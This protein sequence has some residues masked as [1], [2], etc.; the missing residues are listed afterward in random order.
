MNNAK[1]SLIGLAVGDAV[2][3]AVEFKERGSFK[4][5]NDMIGGGPHGLQAG[6]WTD[7][8]SMALCLAESLIED[9]FDLKSQLQKYLHWYQDGYLS[10]TGRCFDIGNNTARSLEYYN[11]TGKLPPERERAAGN[12]SLMRLA[13]IPIYF[14]DNYENAVYYSGESSKTTHN[15]I[16]AIDSCRYFGGLLQLALQRE[17]SSKE[18]LLDLAIKNINLQKRVNNIARGSFKNKDRNEIYADGFVINSLEAS[19]WA[20][21]NTDSFDEAVLKVVNLG[22]DADTT[23]AIT[24]QIAGTYYGID[25]IREEWIEKLALKDQ[26]LNL[27]ERLV[28]SQ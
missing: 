22:E 11:D 26:I 6:Q 15:N 10:S 9:G 17:I 8:T 27:C 25:N 5:V 1:G 21:Y 3:A 16:L 28:K 23:G 4:E 19:L 7:D 18:E 24:G 12:G 20:F 13:P 14:S 2:G